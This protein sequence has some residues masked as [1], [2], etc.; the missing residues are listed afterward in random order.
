MP[1]PPDDTEHVPGRRVS[2][3]NRNIGKSEHDEHRRQA[4]PRP[5]VAVTSAVS[6][7]ASYKHDREYIDKS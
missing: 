4:P 2:K 3:N 5:D 1:R 6:E 7:V